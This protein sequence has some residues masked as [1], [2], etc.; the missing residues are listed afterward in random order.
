MATADQLVVCKVPTTPDDQ[1]E[2]FDLG[3]REGLTRAGAASVSSI[4]H[5]TTVATNAVLE[6]RGAVTALVTTEGFADLLV[7]GRQHRP[8]L[9]DL[10]A[11]RPEPLVLRARA[12]GVRERVGPSGEILTPLDEAA[13]RDVVAALLDA[14]AESIAICLL[15][16]F[17]NPAHER[18]IASLARERSPR[19]RVSLSS[20]VSPEF[21]E[22][23]RASTV[24]LDAYVGPVVERYLG[25][26]RARIRARSA[27]LGVGVVV[28][29][30]GGATMTLEEAVREPIHTLLSGPAAGVRG[31][32]VVAGAAGLHDLVTFDMGGT[33]TD[34]C[35]V[36]GGE[37]AL[38]A[39]SSIGGL[40]FRTP[41]VAVH[42]VGAGGGSLL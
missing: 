39:E 31:A 28:M 8:S 11:N 3:L 40:P 1:S 37:P 32:V 25:R 14:G 29:R 27:G 2:G 35:L 24:A 30:S 9:Y 20:D 19:V 38:A 18:R 41:A 42:T 4:A 22:Y 36:E 33:S 5:G 16:S 23:E 10:W 13:A 15:F 26:I 6:R 21:R 17:A 7:I 12:A 34:V